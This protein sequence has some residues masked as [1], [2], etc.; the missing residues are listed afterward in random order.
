V[1]SRLNPYLNFNGT[2]R[3]AMEFYAGVF[4][5]ELSLTTF[6]QLGADGPDADRVM[7]AALETD[8]GYLIMGA[9]VPSGMD[10]EPVT[11]ASVSLSGDDGEALRGY[12]AQLSVGG[13]V[14]MPLEKQAWGDEFGMCVDQFGVPWMVNI[15][16]P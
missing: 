15:S 4:G 10:Y 1:A 14:R 6:A 7:H 9:D 13:T 2:A 12:F 11:G 3:Q 16:E 8:A 5:G